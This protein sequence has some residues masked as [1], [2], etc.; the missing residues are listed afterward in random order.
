MGFRAQHPIPVLRIF[1][2]QKARDFYVDYLGFTVDW[3]HRFDGVTPLYMQISRGKIVLHL[4]EHHGDGTP[5]TV[6]YVHATG[7]EDLHAEL[8]AKSY[9]YLRPGLDRS[10]GSIGLSL[11]DPFGNELR[12][13]DRR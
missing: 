11:R 12:I 10:D 9:G 7:V 3:E 2:V 8:Q 6:V 13:E 5:G 4:S 1:D